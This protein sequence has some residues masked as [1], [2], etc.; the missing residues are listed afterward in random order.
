M[1]FSGEARPFYT[2]ERRFD[3]VLRRVVYAISYRRSPA[4]CKIAIV[5]SPGMFSVEFL[6][7]I[8]D[9]EI[10][11]I[12]PYL[13]PGA[14]ILEIGGGTGYQAKLLASRGFAVT[15]IDLPN[16]NY[17]DH[18]VYPVIRYD[19]RQ[20]PFA[21][22]SFDI[23]F[24]SNLLEHVPDVTQLHRETSRVLKPKGYAVHVLP[25]SAWRFW[26]IIASY[27][28]MVQRIILE[29][30]RCLSRRS[31]RQSP[32]A[33]M[34]NALGLLRHYIVVPRHGETG[35]ALTE[36]VSFSAVRWDRHF[37]AHRLTVTVRK[38]MC[39][40]YTGHL[41]LG[42]RM[43]LSIRSLLAR[44]LGSACMLWVVKFPGG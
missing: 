32:R 7:V 43:S 26:T 39:L 37:R 31:G 17:R 22:H 14:R 4:R 27:V 29:F 36:L 42:K 5:L 41:V 15:A 18:Q 10:R 40:F 6:H 23:V 20:F 13:T 16:S 34:R 35:N 11:T 12:L 9:H 3:Q 19:G 28:E 25:T 44:F 21:N 24:S 33:A 2:S 1:F 38:P 8:R 30:G